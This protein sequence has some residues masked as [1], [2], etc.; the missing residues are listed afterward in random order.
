MNQWLRTAADGQ[1]VS[2]G[3][4]P[5][6]AASLL[7]EQGIGALAY[8]FLRDAADLPEAA[9]ARLRRSYE[10]AL[11][12]KD[13]AAAVLRELAGG[14]TGSG[15]IVLMQGL[16]LCEYVYPEPWARP[17][18]DIDLYLPDNNL[19]EVC[20]VLAGKGFSRYRTYEGVW[21]RSGLMIDLHE[22][23]FGGD[24]IERRRGLLPAVSG[25]F[26]PSALVP[27]CFV[28]LPG[29][30]ALQAALHALKHAF[31]KKKWSFDLYRL[32]RA[33]HMEQLLATDNSYLAA[34]VVE[35]LERAGLLAIREISVRSGRMPRLRS[36][37]MAAAI[38]HGS[39]EGTGE[40]A[41]ALSC[42]KIS[43]TLKYLGASIVPPKKILQEIY[44]N[45]PRPVLLMK[46]IIALFRMVLR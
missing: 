36:A 22:D 43:D 16:A 7:D 5:E 18:S 31:A 21:V 40:L 19:P 14:C 12:Y 13:L 39:R 42:R 6:T 33:G 38:R 27:G 8:P 15:R 23:L 41:L 24:R 45:H 20:A 32:L 34:A 17:M 28:S 26:V 35:E 37:L 3:S 1:P 25:E 11:L 44:G 29:A 10:N 46:R 4:L 9:R 2:R 30:V